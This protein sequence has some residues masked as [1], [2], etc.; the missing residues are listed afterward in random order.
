MLWFLG[1]IVLK[2]TEM[3]IYCQQQR[4]SPRCVVSGDISLM[5]IFLGVRWW[6]DVKCECGRRKCEFCLSIA[7]SSVRSSPLALHIEI[8]YTASHGFPATARLLFTEAVLSN[9]LNQYWYV[10]LCHV[11]FVRE[12]YVPIDCRFYSRFLLSVLA[13]IKGKLLA[14]RR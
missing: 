5:P 6:R 14:Q 7:I 1:M 4:C 3:H 2:C 8:F 11:L 9:G 13:I 10:G 12:S